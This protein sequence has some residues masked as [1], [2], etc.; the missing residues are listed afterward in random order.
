VKILTTL[1]LAAALVACA[2]ALMPARRDLP[3][4]AAFANQPVDAKPGEPAGRF[5]QRFGD[6]QLDALVARAIEANHDLRI[7]TANL[8][9]ARALARDADAQR[10]P[11]ADVVA[12]A[13]RV[14]DSTGPGRA[15]YVV[16]FDVAWEADLFGRLSGAQAAAGA[17]VLATEAHLQAVKLSLTA[18][19]ARTYFEL[20]GLQERLRVVQASLETQQAVLRL[21]QARHDAGRGVALDTERARALAATTAAG[22]PAL[23]A[24]LLRSRYR[25]AVLSGQ[26]PTVLDAELADVRPLP[27]L[28]SVSLGSI[29]SPEG[30]LLRRPDVRAALHA[31]ATA[32]A[33]AGVAR[34][35]LFP[36]ITLGGTLGQ[37]ASQPGNLLDGN[38]YVYN[39]GAQLVWNLLDFGRV[40]AQI[41]AADA[42]GEA[43]LAVWER[44]VLT[45]LE[46]TE[47]ALVTYTRTQ[48]Q[49][50][51]LFDAAR[52]AEA[53]ARIARARFDAG[54]I[55]FLVVLDAE[56]E[57]LAARDRLALSQSN[58]ATS[59][60]GVYKALAGD[61]SPQ[62]Q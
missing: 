47:G 27:G 17:T 54:V 62:Q 46:E 10:W 53:A 45:A 21:V 41:A 40:R 3:L 1:L 50:Q 60:V 5:W 36:R 12:G 59:L 14:R 25:L 52:A 26:A 28:R 15:L 11:Q 48:R 58:A 32:A 22:I 8:Q 57:S 24:A 2:P 6:A 49:A 51:H 4:D 16:G 19:V 18:E 20:R 39:L 55:D 23:E 30:L 42:R 7:A 31:A 29:G 37:N 56:R 13:G 61:V 43:A 44:T 9:E 34:S 33:R 35:A 38:A